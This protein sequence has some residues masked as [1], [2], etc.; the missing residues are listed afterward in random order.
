MLVQLELLILNILCSTHVSKL[1]KKKVSQLRHGAG[2]VGLEPLLAPHARPD[3]TLDRRAL[4]AALEATLGAD[5][6]N[7]Q[8]LSWAELDLAAHTLLRQLGGDGA[9]ARGVPLHKL[10]AWLDDVVP[11]GS[12]GP[13]RGLRST[14]APPR[15]R[16]SA[17]GEAA[18]AAPLAARATLQLMLPLSNRACESGF[19]QLFVEGLSDALGVS[20]SRLRVLRAQPASPVVEFEVAPGPVS[21]L[22]PEDALDALVVQ[23]R[24]PRSPLRAGCLAGY[25]AG[26]SLVGAQP[27]AGRGFPSEARSLSWRPAPPAARWL[28]GELARAL[29]RGE[30]RAAEA[31]AVLDA[32]AVRVSSRRP[33]LWCLPGTLAQGQLERLA[34]EDQLGARKGRNGV[35]TN[36]NTASVMF[37]LTKA[38]AQKLLGYFYSKK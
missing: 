1:I 4:S 5:A 31:A 12:S 8:A 9:S 28:L 14:S 6:G 38:L 35:S 17:R 36:G 24:Q 25:L 13:A 16:F 29:H 10:A 26:A 11:R 7:L 3:G 19:P 30:L 20:Q 27:D 21:E 18:Q 23:L 32:A 37:L 2:A 33:D 15:V 22:S 34:E